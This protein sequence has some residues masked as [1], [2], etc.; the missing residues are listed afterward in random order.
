MIVASR[1]GLMLRY[2]R[3][4]RGRFISLN[5]RRFPSGLDAFQVANK[6]HEPGLSE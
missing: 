1:L 5:D 3:G 4:T 2:M 6:D